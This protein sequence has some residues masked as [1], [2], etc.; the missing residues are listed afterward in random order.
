MRCGGR[1]V[2]RLQCSLAGT[3]FLLEEVTHRFHAKVWVAAFVSAI[4]A[5]A[6][7]FPFFGTQPCLYLPIK[8]GLPT[9]AYPWLIVLGVAIGALAF[10]FQYFI[11]NLKWWYRKFTILPNYY[12][13]I[14]P[15]LLVIP[16]GLWNPHI[17][18]G[19]HNFIMYV[20]DTSLHAD[21]LPLLGM[22]I[23]SSSC[24]SSGP[25]WP[26]GPRFPAV[27]SCRSS[28]WEA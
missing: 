12:H 7:T 4:A 5:D 9:G 19:S 13:S 24:V 22:M 2:R 25:C 16:V 26:M 1:T 17:L 18:G 20:A 10:L 14:L 15:L 11:F 23:C 8:T 21:W 3:V 28:F 6:V 27:S